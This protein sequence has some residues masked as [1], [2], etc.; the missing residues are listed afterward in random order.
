L[1]GCA[2]AEVKV[3]SSTFTSAGP[4]KSCGSFE[5]H[6]CSFSLGQSQP[7]AWVTSD[8]FEVQMEH[9]RLPKSLSGTPMKA[10]WALISNK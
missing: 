5:L 10:L 3:F 8:P 4:G 7:S 1:R 2:A 9:F 6:C